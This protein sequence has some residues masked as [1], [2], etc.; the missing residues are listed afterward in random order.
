MKVSTRNEYGELKSVIVGRCEQHA[1]PTD[2][3]AFDEMIE[4]ST[5]PNTLPRETL[6]DVVTK[7]AQEDLQ[8]M[9]DVL[10]SRNITVYRTTI[11]NPNWCYS[12]RDIMLSIGNRI[13]ECPTMYTSRINE[14]DD[15][16]AD[17]KQQA[18]A[19][20]CDWIKAPAPQ[21]ADDPT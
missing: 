2:D 18:I 5:Y 15:H 6:P 7:Q 3:L 13:I 8:Y 20:G 10:E 11:T 4:A 19:D 12:S 21:T 1:W 17:I 9:A 14:A 16:Y